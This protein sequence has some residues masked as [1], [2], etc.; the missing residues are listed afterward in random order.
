M[1]LCSRER[2]PSNIM[3]T[4]RDQRSVRQKRFLHLPLY[5][6]VHTT[7]I[8]RTMRVLSSPCTNRDVWCVRQVQ[9]NNNTTLQIRKHEKC[10]LAASDGLWGPAREH[11]VGDIRSV[12]S[13]ATGGEPV[14]PEN[15][16]HTDS[17]FSCFSSLPPRFFSAGLG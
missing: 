7:T 15:S 16:L 11:P 1:T 2:I 8:Q 13:H 6:A 14:V 10:L 17:R 9:T 5:I 4:Q 3:F 12:A